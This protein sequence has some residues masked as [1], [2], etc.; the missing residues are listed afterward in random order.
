VLE[1]H[2]ELTRLLLDPSESE[3]VK[4]GETLGQVLG[5]LKDTKASLR[6]SKEQLARAARRYRRVQ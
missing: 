2:E 3:L 6:K 5:D 1:K 4:A